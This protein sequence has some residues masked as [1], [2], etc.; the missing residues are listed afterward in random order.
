[1]SKKIAISEFKETINEARYLEHLYNKY[2]N[3]YYDLGLTIT[4]ERKIEKLI[5]Y[6]VYHRLLENSKKNLLGNRMVLTGYDS[7]AYEDLKKYT[8]ILKKIK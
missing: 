1:M 8:A 6:D 3:E 4:D 2:R 7:V 5:N